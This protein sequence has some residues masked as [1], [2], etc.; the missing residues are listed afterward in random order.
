MDNFLISFSFCITKRSACIREKENMD[1][2]EIENN[3]TDRQKYL[4]E[5][6]NLLSERLYIEVKKNK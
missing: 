1:D 6:S 5:V 4:D 3:R 2:K